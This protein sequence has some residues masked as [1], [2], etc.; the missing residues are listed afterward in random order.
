MSEPWRSATRSGL[1]SWRTASWLA[2]M[3]TQ[4]S[5]WVEERSQSDN[6]ASRPGR[7]GGAQFARVCAAKF[8]YHNRHFCGRRFA[9]RHALTWYRTAT[10]CIPPFDEVRIVR[11]GRGYLPARLA[12]L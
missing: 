9:G 11:Y 8:A 3:Q 5:S 7:T 6:E 4:P 1:F 2:M 12:K 10:A